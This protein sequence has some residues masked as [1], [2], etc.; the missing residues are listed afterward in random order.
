MTDYL[1]NGP[2]YCYPRDT[3]FDT[4]N[5]CNNEYTDLFLHVR[6]AVQIS[7]FLLFTLIL[8]IRPFL[9][10]FPNQRKTYNILP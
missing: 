4:G 8:K 2:P 10:G 9:I 1:T 3:L 6:I 7:F 5:A